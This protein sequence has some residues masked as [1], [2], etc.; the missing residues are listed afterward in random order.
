MVL[1]TVLATVLAAVLVTVL[2]TV[3]AAVLATVLG[4]V[5]V[6]VLAAVLAMVLAT[7]QWIYKTFLGQ[8]DSL[9]C[10]MEDE[11]AAEQLRVV[12]DKADIGP[13]ISLPD[14]A[15][16]NDMNYMNVTF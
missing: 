1:A 13:S 10:C 4:T 2:A 12:N 9:C 15:V 7:E 3:L 11:E 16:K 8:L 6:A 14:E 5:L